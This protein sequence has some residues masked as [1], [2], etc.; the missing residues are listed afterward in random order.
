MPPFYPRGG[1]TDNR[2]LGVIVGVIL[3]GGRASRLGGGD[4]GLRPVGGRPILARI[5][6]RLEP[7]VDRLILNAN[8]DPARFAFLGLEVVADGA[9]GLPGPLAGVLAGLD[10]AAELGAAAIVTVPGD[11]PFVPGD[12]A[13]RLAAAG[14]FAMA[15]GPDGRRHPTFGRWPVAQREALAAGIAAGARR[16]GDWMAGKGAVE[17]PFP[18]ADGFLNV[19]APEDL[20]AA[21]AVAARLG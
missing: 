15:T 18:E 6:A 7:Q 9:P 5:V 19:N 10:R 16:V 14:P 21:E 20:A 2:G 4:K 3:A 12:L 17:A 1:G 8:G 11:A 13:A